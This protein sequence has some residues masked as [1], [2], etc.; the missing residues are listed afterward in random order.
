MCRAGNHAGPTQQ[1]GIMEAPNPSG[2]CK[3]GCGEKT[4]LARQTSSRYGHVAGEHVLYVHGHHGRGK[5][6]SPEAIQKMSDARKKWHE[7]NVS[8]WLGRK[9]SPETIEKMK[10]SQ[11]RGPGHTNWRGGRRE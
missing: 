1:E 3:C 2:L 11:P 8:P 6:K 9:H 5:T 7:E 10:R 4:P